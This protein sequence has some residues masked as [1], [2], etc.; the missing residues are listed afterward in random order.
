MNNDKMKNMFVDFDY[1]FKGG[2]YNK[3]RDKKLFQKLSK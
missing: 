3:S 2:N 1:G